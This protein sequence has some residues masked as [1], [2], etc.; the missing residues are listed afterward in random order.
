MFQKKSAKELPNDE[1]KEDVER[2]TPKKRYLSPEE[3]QHVI[4]ELRLLPKKD[5]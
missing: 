5:V 2:V 1:T 3:R 4:D